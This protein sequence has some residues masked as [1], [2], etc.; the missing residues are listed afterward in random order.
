MTGVTRFACVLMMLTAVAAGAQNAVVDVD[1]MVQF[2]RAV[3][4]HAF[5]HR[6][7]ERRGV[8]PP[9]V[10][11]AIFTPTIAAAFRS[12]IR[13]VQAGC[14]LPVKDSGT[15]EVPRVNMSTQSTSALPTCV[16]A[17]LPVLPQDLEYRSAGV[18]LL[19]T[20]AR[21]HVVVDVLH[22]AFPSPVAP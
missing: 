2:Q 4:S 17:V 20:D 9:A 13:K 5:A 1:A 8:H 14:S 16:V 18:A 15:F 10:E 11:G 6:Q 21:R 7:A 22:A 12:R 19:L 3:D